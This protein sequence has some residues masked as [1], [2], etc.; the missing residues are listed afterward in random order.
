MCRFGLWLT[1]KLMGPPCTHLQLNDLKFRG[2]KSNNEKF[3]TLAGHNKTYSV[4]HIAR[5]SV[6]KPNPNQLFS[7]YHDPKY[8]C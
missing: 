7:C 2:Q 4:P 6:T 3:L 8:Y 5:P 1:I